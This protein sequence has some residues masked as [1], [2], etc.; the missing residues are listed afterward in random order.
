MCYNMVI[1]FFDRLK[2]GFEVHVTFRKD[3]SY[4]ITAYH[5]QCASASGISIRRRSGYMPPAMKE[6]IEETTIEW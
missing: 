1:K 2:N 5:G 6:W 4:V 3:R